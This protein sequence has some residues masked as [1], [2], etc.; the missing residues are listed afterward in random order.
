MPSSPRACPECKGSRYVWTL[1]AD[2]LEASTC[3]FWRSRCPE[4][5]STGCAENEAIDPSFPDELEPCPDLIAGPGPGFVG[6]VV[7]AYG[8]IDTG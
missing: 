3:V 2:Q 8:E 1:P 7:G 6:T 4:C 5:G